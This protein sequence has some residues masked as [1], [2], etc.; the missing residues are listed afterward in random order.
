MHTLGL[1]ELA[2][3]NSSP[4]QRHS[5]ADMTAARITWADQFPNLKDIPGNLRLCC[6]WG[7]DLGFGVSAKQAR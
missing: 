1:R 5:V 2:P 6:P 7:L 4:Q 3:S